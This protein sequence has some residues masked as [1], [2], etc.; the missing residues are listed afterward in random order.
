MFIKRYLIN[1]AAL[2][3]LIVFLIR[4]SDSEQLPLKSDAGSFEKLLLFPLGE[5]IFQK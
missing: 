4:S 1:K 5:M 3:K 2:L